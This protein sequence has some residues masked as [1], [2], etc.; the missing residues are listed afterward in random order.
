[1]KFAIVLGGKVSSVVLKEFLTLP[2]V[3]VDNGITDGR[4]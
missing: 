4:A 1:M 3:R 2:M